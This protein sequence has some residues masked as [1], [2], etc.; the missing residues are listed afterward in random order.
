MP[1]KEIIFF[2]IAFIFCKSLYAQTDTLFWFAPPEVSQDGVNE[3]DRPIIL[4][5][6]AISQAATVTVALPANPSFTPISI[7]I[8]SGSTNSIDLTPW[9]DLIES[10]PPNMILNTGIKVSSTAKVNVY[11]E[12]VSGG[13]G[14]SC[15]C[16]PE[17]FV[18][19]GKSALGKFF[20]IPSQNLLSN[21]GWTYVPP[22]THSFDIV[23]T[24]DNTTIT[25]NPIRDIVGHTASTSF[26]ITLNKGQVYSCTASNRLNIG[27]LGG[28]TVTSNKKIAITL[29]DDSLDNATCRD[30]GGDQ[31]IP[32]EN[33][34]TEYIAIQGYLTLGIT[35]RVFITAVF[36][37]TSIYVAGGL[38]TIIN[39]NQTI[40]IPFST[41]AMYITSNNK[42]YAFQMSGSDCEV[43]LSSIPSIT[44]S[45]SSE[46]TFTRSSNAPLSIL[47]ATQ[48]V[49]QSSFVLNGSPINTS[50][51][52]YVPGTANQYVF[53]RII[54]PTSQI[55]ALT[56]ARLTNSN[57]LFH[58]GFINGDGASGGVRF[59]YF[60]DFGSVSATAF[61]NTINICP[62]ETINL[63]ADTVIS[64]TYNWSGPNGFT[65][66]QQNPIIPNTT[67]ANTGNYILTVSVPNCGNYL[68]SVN[69][70]VKP[71]SLSSITQTICQGQAY[72]G[73]ITSG[74]YYDT[75]IAVN[76]CDSIR[77]LNLTVL[78]ILASTINKSICQG[79]S[80]AGYTSTGIYVDTLISLNGCDSIR[81]LSLTVK[82]N[83]SSDIVTSICEG[84]NFLGHTI[85]GTYIDTLIS[86]IGCDSIISTKL[87][88]LKNCDVYFPSA[89]TPNNDSNNDFFKIL[90]ANN[91]V[92][93]KLSIYNR[94][95][96]K[97]FE[98]KDY[99]VGWNGIYK[100]ILQPIGVYVWYSKFKLLGKNR[101]MKG[102]VVLIR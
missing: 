44:C 86:F 29:K 11:Y 91:V 48:T 65:S 63:F 80:Y 45:G 43:G 54:V 62:G 72:L 20:T 14:V 36:N 73:Y 50:N 40:A 100:G 18:L 75:L 52:N 38:Y 31:I 13:Y 56:S 47:I 88:V 98:T 41:P 53:A 61:T 42:I 5:I 27:H 12:V 6:S 28:S 99:T 3:F 92:E 82:A 89:F 33:L 60:S 26:T 70:N 34:S 77:T 94:W 1:L 55:P 96:L 25:I 46:V 10:K 93:Y 17:I 35:D 30:M 81:K 9:I 24:E 83:S 68:D 84:E 23:A 21:G 97:V 87:T 8:S 71:K 58:L 32:I 4:R 22:A 79:E 16:N 66:N 7:N 57:G 51:F 85:N 67:L 59:G 15:Q 19:K 39:A 76:G 2:F 49:N 69:I 37:N 101:E 95:G 102:T 78:P 64:A 90:N 74:I